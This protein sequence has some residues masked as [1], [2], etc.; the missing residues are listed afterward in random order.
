M[1]Y[2]PFSGAA[3]LGNVSEADAPQLGPLEGSFALAASVSDVPPLSRRVDW[4][5]PWENLGAESPGLQHVAVWK[6]DA[7]DS[8]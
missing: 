8:R 6:V 5:R 1:E 3:R 7:I 2:L 4:P